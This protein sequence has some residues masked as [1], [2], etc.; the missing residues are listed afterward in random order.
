MISSLYHHI[1]IIKLEVHPLY[2]E[3][4]STGIAPASGPPT[5]WYAPKLQHTRWFDLFVPEDR[6][7]AMRC[8][9]GVLS[10]T[11][12]TG[13]E[14]EPLGQRQKSEISHAFS[15]RKKKYEAATDTKPPQRAHSVA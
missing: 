4:L 5:P 6:V 13:T 7:E 2:M 9:W 15:F 1:A 3:Y 12:R 11:M 14:S 10:Y 8:I